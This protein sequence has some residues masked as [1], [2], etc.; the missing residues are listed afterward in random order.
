MKK[1]TFLT[2]QILA[3]ATLLSFGQTK[4]VDFD[5]IKRMSNNDSY[6]ILFDRFKANDTTLALDDY[7]VLYYGQAYRQ[8]YKPNER[9]DSV[10][11][12]NTYLNK[13]RASIDFH[14]VLGYTKQ[15]LTDL[16]FNI[17]QIYITGIAYDRLGVQDSSKIWL[18]KYNKLIQTIMSSGDGK[19]IKTA[20]VVTK[21]SDE[22]SILNALG[23]QFKKQEL[24][25]RKQRSCDLISVAENEYGINELYFDVSLFFGKW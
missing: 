17:E 2:F 5:A 9:H 22:Y 1:I 19:T 14:K 11:A 21:I 10:R 6:E 3:L 25:N 23:L 13:N 12:L 15:I 20:F 8:N 4:S 18:Y 16:P 24:V 7:V